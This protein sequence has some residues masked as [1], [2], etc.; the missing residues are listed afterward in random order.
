MIDRM[1][2]ERIVRTNGVDLCV[3]TFGEPSAPAILLIA[4]AASSMEGWPEE[5]C[6]QLAAASRFVIRYDHRDTGRS[7]SYP[8]GE[9]GYT[10]SD[11]EADALGILDAL[12]VGRAHLVGVSM[13]GGMA[14]E[15]AIEHPDRVASLTLIATSSGPADDLPPVVPELRALFN[16]P[17]PEPDWSDRA[18]VI[19]YIVAGERP[20]LGSVGRDDAELRGTAARVVERTANLRSALSNHWI[21][22]GGDD[23]GS[24]PLRSRLGRIT[25][26]TLVIH[27]TSD[28]LFPFP[29]GE[30]LAA[31]I[32]GARLL[33]LDGVG[34]EV[35]PRPTWPTVLTA[36]V[37][38]TA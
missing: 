13:G 28:P 18:A 17:P 24:E 31:E 33:P 38:H 14:Q 15:L 20:F 25:A 8:P 4:G 29:H 19:D 34:H 30:A 37:A 11:L 21:M 16:D 23:D 6:A 3:Q 36:L 12:G 27:G 26:P 10:A 22:V 2:A 1:S 32:P 5:L 35:P 9:P 7:T